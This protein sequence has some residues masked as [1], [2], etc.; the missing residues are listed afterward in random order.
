MRNALNRHDKYITYIYP[1]HT[2]LKNPNPA[3]KAP[4][5]RRL[6]VYHRRLLNDQANSLPP[7]I[8]ALRP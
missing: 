5:I 4:S 1:P 3:A 2:I 6:S 7:F 8:A